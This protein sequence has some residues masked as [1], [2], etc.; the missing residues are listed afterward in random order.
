MSQG[1]LTESNF[2]D[3]E[4]LSEGE[5]STKNLYIEGKFMQSDVVNRNRRMYPLSIMEREV[6]NYV[7]EWV[8][9]KRAVGELNHP[10]NTEINMERITHITESVNQVGKDFIGKARILN[11]PSGNIVRGLLEGGV[12]LGVSSRGTGSVKPN[13]M[14]INEVQE[15]FRL[16]A[17]DIVFSPS[18]PDAFVEGLMENASFVWDTINEDVEFVEQIQKDIKCAKSKDLQEAKI[19]AFDSFLKNLR[20]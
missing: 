17:V 18:A 4:V 5:G 14:G 10:D 11:T 3:V 6:N 20:S 7:R 12:R 13:K 15:D 16:A 2:S 8:V 19:A 1:I 9:P